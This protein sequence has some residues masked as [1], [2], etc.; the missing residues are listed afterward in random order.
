MIRWFARRLPRAF[1]LA[2]LPA[3]AALAQST[4]GEI[5]GFVRDSTGGVL[6]GVTVTLRYPDIALSRTVVTDDSGYFVFPGVPPGRADLH[7]TLDGFTPASRTNV[8]VELNARMRV[9]LSMS[10]GALVESVEVVAETAPAVSTRADISH[11]VTGEQTKEMPI[12]GRSYMQLMALVPGV[13]RNDSSYEFGTS[14]RAD[15]QQVNGLRKNFAAV[16]LDGSENL[17]AGSNATQ[18]NNV[19]IDAIEEFRVMTGIYSAEF[20]K[21]GGA[22]INVVTKSGKKD[23]HGSLYDF[24]RDDRFDARNFRTGQKDVLDFNNFGWTLG[25]PIAWPGFNGDRSKLFF[26]VGQ[27]WKSLDSQVGQTKVATTPSLLEREGDFSQSP[28]V[29][30]DPLTGQPFPGGVIPR[31]RLS[32][33]GLALA[34]RFPLPDPGSRNSVTMTP[35]QVRDIHEDIVRI[36]LRP[37]PADNVTGRYIR[38]RVEQVE[39]YGSFGGTAGYDTV[40]TSHDRYSDSVMLGYNHPVGARLFHE[41]S[42]NLVRN[43]Q[44]LLQ[45]GELYQRTGLT[46]PELFPVNRG[47]RAPNITTLTGYS[48]GTGL[49]GTNYPTNLVGNYYTLKDNWTWNRGTHT[50]KAG[51]YLGHFR[52]AEETRTADAGSFTFADNQTGGTGVA[53]AN[54]LLGR[55]NQYSE[56]DVAPYGSMRYNQIELYAQDHWQ[57]RP[58]FTLD[59][60]VRWQ[61]MPAMF[62]RDDRIST[63]DPAR[64][65]PARAPQMTSSGSL[66]AGTGDPLNGIV[67]AGQ[68]GVPRGLYEADVNNFAP[69]IGFTWDPWRNGRSAVR[70]GF[71][72]FFDR[73]VTNATRDQA[74]SPPFVNTVVISNGSI[75]NPGGGAASTAP[76]GGFEALAVDFQAPTVYQW[77]VG[78]QRSLPW[79]MALDM[80]FVS[81]EARHLLRVRELNYATPG[82][83]GVAP[84]PVNNVRQYVGYGRI[85]INE[86]TASSDYRGLQVSLNRRSDGN[87]AWGLAYTLSRAR[88]DADS[89]DSTS[90]GSLAQDPR[91]P[92]AEW[93]PQDFSRRHV[94]AVN[95]QWLVPFYKEGR[96]LMGGLLGGWQFNGI[97]KYN[98]GRRL[99]ITAGTNTAIFGDQVTIRANL[100]EGQDPNAEPPGGRTE[101]QWLNVA[102]FAR[103]ATNTLGTL[104]RNA[105][106]GPSFSSTDLSLVK[107]VRVAMVRIQFRAEAFNVFNQKN[108]RTVETN[109]TNAN[110]GRV[111]EY[112]AQRIMQFGAKLSF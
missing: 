77:S 69:R 28:R 57:A 26:F 21:A 93:G 107:N 81:N 76:L 91:D 42:L 16:T 24:L 38:D 90:S 108:Y 71:G 41:F 27:E 13:S 103:P 37:R 100:V 40:P 18:V 14:F 112:E 10:V 95:Y 68:G 31:N 12:D 88:G 109:I 20:G 15:A 66:V 101:Q 102:A 75:D 63:F 50:V 61:Y 55:F 29:P 79:N 73:P 51:V 3:A 9:D 45:T 46:M 22:Q 47:G 97:T 4:T 82:T 85:T 7:A 60:G 105:V 59:Y 94:L 86:T 49:F 110:F 111:T 6:P 64:Y 25:G 99:N 35:S 2:V 44:R 11:L 32:A 39:P 17:D 56:A 78:Y 43:D 65:D 1:A 83:G 74:A 62:E 34:A 30:T 72:I 19:S 33:N 53:L 36:D 70:G 5:A 80:N 52:K 106:E 8:P 48:L 87:H 54:L 67:V 58:N 104:A 84:A 96:G 89:E 98:S 92:E 23:F